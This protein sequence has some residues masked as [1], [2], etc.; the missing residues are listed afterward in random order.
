MKT[1]F[2]ILAAALVWPALADTT[3]APVLRSTNAW[4]WSTNVPVIITNAVTLS[5]NTPGAAPAT[6][7][8]IQRGIVLTTNSTAVPISGTYAAGSGYIRFTNIVVNANYQL[9]PGANELKLVN[10]GDLLLT[11]GVPVSFLAVHEFIELYGAP[12]SAVTAHL[13]NQVINSATGLVTNYVP[14][15]NA[16]FTTNAPVSP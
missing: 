15:F 5:T 12:S 14:R 9:T 10:G 4:N 8:V 16:G 2:T 6:Q 13:T 7:R 1:L 11:N 3:N